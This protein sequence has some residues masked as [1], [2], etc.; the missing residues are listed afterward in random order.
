MPR[1]SL[2]SPSV[3]NTNCNRMN[4]KHLMTL[5]ALLF[6]AGASNAQTDQL[7]KA[8][9]EF[10]N[11]GY[12]EAAELFK[13][14][15]KKEKEIDVKAMILFKTGECYKNIHRYADAEAYYEKSITAK[16]YKQDEYVYFALG[17]TLLEQ[18]K[19]DEAIVQFNKFKE[20]GGDNAMAEGASKEAEN[21][22][23]NIE[24]SESRYEI[25]LMASWNTPQHDYAPTIASKGKKDDEVVFSSSR[26]ASSGS[27]EDPKT[28]EDFM[29]L[30]YTER[31]K[32]G[33]WDNP[34]VLNNTVNSESNEGTA[35]FSKKRDIMYFTRCIY[36]K[37]DRFG[38]DIYWAKKQGTKYGPATLIN[39]KP[40][41]DDTSHVGH[42]FMSQDGKYLLFSSNLPGG[43]G[44]KDLY[45]SEFDK[46]N[47]TWSSP[48]NLG[49]DINTEDDEMFPF[50]RSDGALYFSSNGHSGYGGLDVFRA[51]ANGDKAWSG[52]A[53]LEYPI[54]SSSDDFSLIFSGE[55]D[56]GFFTSNRPGGKGM[57]D[58]YSFLMPPLEFVLDAVVYNAETG[59]PIPG[60]KVVISGTDNSSF[61]LQAD[62]NGGVKMDNGEI[63]EES[64]YTGSISMDG[65]IATTDQF[66]TVGLDR[67]T[68]FAKEYFLEPII[69]EKPMTFPEV[70]YDFGKWALQVNNEVNSA[71]SLD[72]LLELLNANP[73]LV[74]E[75][76]AHTDTR[77]SDAANK[78]LSEKRAK[79]CKDY[80][81]ANGIAADRLQSRGFGEEKTLVSDAEIAAMATKEEQEA[82]HQR[83]RRTEF[84]IIRFDYVPKN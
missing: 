34:K 13:I 80:L 71:D 60:A 26:P 55:E 73:N 18:G 59:E 11:Q 51:E 53:N 70:R 7:K 68:T 56:K 63:K 12:S 14:A 17:E 9:L 5:V 66:S 3:I 28:G 29:D 19:Y 20:N 81:I 48:K 52:V 15:Y 76:Q 30:Y 42:P 64:T 21:A 84:A 62:G 25:D 31:D 58:I 45:Y 69:V 43:Y 39:L 36:T 78:E 22:S 40:E 16:Y 67:S 8:L 2:F 10:D 75:L 65:F 83:N 47:D 41:G 24:E 77:G 74:V 57:D 54:N 33:K 44:G 1:F 27:D 79:T 49:A 61:D 50:V 38:C 6:L 72:F 4:F 46:K 37:D 23:K 82:G 35:S 32:K